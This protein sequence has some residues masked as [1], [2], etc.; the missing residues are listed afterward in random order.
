MLAGS[1]ARPIASRSLFAASV[2]WPRIRKPLLYKAVALYA[3]SG[4]YMLGPEEVGVVQRFGR[5]LPA[6]R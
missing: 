2:L 5:K 1:A 4:L 6:D 3:L